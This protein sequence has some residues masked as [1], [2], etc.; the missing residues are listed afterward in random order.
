[1]QTC[2]NQHPQPGGQENNETRGQHG[3]NDQLP[4]LYLRIRLPP[5][6]SNATIIIVVVDYIQ[7]T[8]GDYQL[9]PYRQRRMAEKKTVARH[10]DGAHPTLTRL[11]TQLITVRVPIIRAVRPGIPFV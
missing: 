11:Q 10:I 1:M 5:T 7:I 2:Y 8:P 3:F 6:D 4:A 9:F